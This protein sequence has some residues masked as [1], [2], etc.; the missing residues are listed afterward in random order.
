MYR[1][2]VRDDHVLE[3]QV[4]QRPQCGEHSLFVPGG[5]PDEELALGGG[6]RVG[7]DEGALLRQP[8]RRLVAATYVVEGDEAAR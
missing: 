2:A 1:L 5:R 3:G 6:Q 7:E 4:E 8:E